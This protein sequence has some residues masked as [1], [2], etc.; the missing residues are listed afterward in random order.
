VAKGESAATCGWAASM[1]GLRLPG[2]ESV[3]AATRGVGCG[4]ADFSRRRGMRKARAGCDLGNLPG[5]SRIDE[6]AG[7]VEYSNKRLKQMFDSALTPDWVTND[8]C[9]TYPTS[10]RRRDA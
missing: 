4:A 10:A 7:D 9:G 2:Q 5:S 6:G 8:A 1:M 3:T